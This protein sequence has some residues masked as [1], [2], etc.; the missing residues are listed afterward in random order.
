VI[1]GLPRILDDPVREVAIGFDRGPA[2]IDGCIVV[3]AED[4]LRVE[5]HTEE[6]VVRAFHRC[7]ESVARLGVS[8]GR[9]WSKHA[10]KALIC[11]K[12]AG[13]ETLIVLIEG[14]LLVLV[15]RRVIRACK[16][17]SLDWVFDKK[18]ERELV[19]HGYKI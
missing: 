12:D 8:R 18:V 9:C 4:L 2:V 11:F 17:F 19:F 1:V 5:L 7:N 13:G 6:R 14:E 16:H 10:F 3:L 15:H